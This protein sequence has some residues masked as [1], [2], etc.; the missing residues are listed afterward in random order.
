MQQYDE[1]AIRNQG[2]KDGVTH[3]TTGIAVV[4]EGKVLLV[5]RSAAD[6]LG[7]MFELPGGGVDEGETIESAAIRELREEIGLI[8][9]DI[10][11]TFQG[12]DYVTPKKPH[13]RQTNFAVTIQDVSKLSL[14]PQEHDEIAW[15]T[16]ASY[17]TYLADNDVLMTSLNDLFQTLL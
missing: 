2:V 9:K 6:Y 17:K 1:V 11:G 3:Y 8:V 12:F 10:L 15:V 4:Y 13:A 14:S 7:G 5:R 16:E